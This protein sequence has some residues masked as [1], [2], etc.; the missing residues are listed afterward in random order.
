[1]LHSEFI[2]LE[3]KILITKKLQ[4]WI[5]EKIKVTLKPIKDDLENIITSADIRSMTYNLFNFLGT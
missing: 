3:K 1:M 2:N 4:E 5:D